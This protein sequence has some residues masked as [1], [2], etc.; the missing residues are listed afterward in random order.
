V[1][2]YRLVTLNPVIDAANVVIQPSQDDLVVLNGSVG[3]EFAVARFRF[4]GVIDAVDPGSKEQLGSCVA[5][6]ATGCQQPQVVGRGALRAI[7]VVVPGGQVKHRCMDAIVFVTQ[8]APVP[9][10]IV[11]GV[12]Q[13]AVIKRRDALQ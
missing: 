1:V 13:P 12:L 2:A 10:W 9:P 5:L 7:V 11:G 6:P 8:F 4:T 3:R